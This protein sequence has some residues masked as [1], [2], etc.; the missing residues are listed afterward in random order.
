M[1]PLKRHEY[2]RLKLADMPPDVI[3]YYDLRKLATPDGS[4]YVRVK[5]GMYG[6]PHSGLL[7][8]E[9]LEER[10]G[11]DGYYQS[12]FTPGLWL[13]KTRP[14]SFSLCVDDFGVKYVGEEH[15]QHLLQSLK[16][17][18]EITVEDEGTRYLGITLEWDYVKRKV[19]LSMPGYVPKALKRFNHEA[20]NRPQD[21]PYP[22][23]PPN[24]GA[25]KQYAKAADNSPPLQK[26]GK[27]FVMQVTGTFLFYARAID[28]TMLP[29]LS[30]IASEQSAPT[31][32]TMK[33]VRQ[34]LDYAASQE[35]A[36]ITYR[37]SDM[38]LNVHSDA[39]YLSKRNA[40][41][42]AGGHHFLSSNEDNPPNNGAILNISQIIKNV[43]SSAAEAE[44]GA[45]FINA[46]TAVP[47]RTT[48]I[49]MG[50]PQPRTPMQTDNSTAYGLINNKI[51]AKATKSV[52]MNFHW[53]RC[54]DS[55][56]QFRYYWAPGTGNLGDYW[57][58]HH[59]PSH[60]QSFR[61]N[62]LTSQKWMNAWRATLPKMRSAMARVC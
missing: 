22:H 52:D 29:A 23:V 11:K 28:S 21:Q 16:K 57:T 54:R 4:I 19:H 53:L 38:V 51:I 62:I 37:A 43:M 32:N 55:Q 36:V 58:K 7:A 61:R 40:R 50:H 20:P 17:H 9:L 24:Y 14:I 48:L 56:G 5:K 33:K 6:L 44:L 46:K 10:L 45:L 42:R 3:E 60:H 30:A 13:H 27:T 12:N 1:T 31:E 41:S 8:Q 47:T 2:L 49:E 15:K 35:E 18:Y 59:P 39:S 26:E 34:F 25:S